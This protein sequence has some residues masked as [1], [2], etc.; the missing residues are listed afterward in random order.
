M[1]LLMHFTA[2]LNRGLA[3]EARQHIQTPIEKHGLLVLAM[4]VMGS[5]FDFQC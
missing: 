3:L 1:S 5:D 2:P 4:R